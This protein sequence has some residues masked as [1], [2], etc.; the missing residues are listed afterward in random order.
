MLAANGTIVLMPVGHS[1]SVPA[2]RTSPSMCDFAYKWRR[3]EKSVILCNIQALT[4]V[5]A[6]AKL[7]RKE[8]ACH[9]DAGLSASASAKEEELGKAVTATRASIRGSVK[10]K[11]PW[12]HQPPSSGNLARAVKEKNPCITETQAL[13]VQL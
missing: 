3:Y 10:G 13:L 9:R 5:V 12:Y 2:R 8:I 6:S 1:A 11:R 4:L 7:K